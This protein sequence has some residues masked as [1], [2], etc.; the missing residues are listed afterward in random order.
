M[1]LPYKSM[2]LYA[3]KRLN[4]QI[5]DFYGRTSTLTFDVK[6]L[7]EGGKDMMYQSV[8]YYI[9]MCAQREMEDMTCRAVSTDLIEDY[10]WDKF[11]KEELNAAYWS[12]YDKSV[13]IK[14]KTYKIET[15]EEFE[16]EK[17]FIALIDRNKSIKDYLAKNPSPLT[18]KLLPDSDDLFEPEYLKSLG[19]TITKDDGQYGE[20]KSI[21]PNGKRIM[22][23]NRDN[24]KSGK[25][26][27]LG[28][29][30]DAG[31]RTVFGGTVET[32]EQLEL[33]LRL[34]K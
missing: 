23:W 3:I 24:M 16:L 25:V 4:I 11:T 20:A 18:P 22:N 13:T 9:G 14:N 6:Q 8:P 7:D 1:M 26:T 10:K 31:T 19:Y 2:S 29:K 27:W 5:M 15:K 33:L 21:N 34:A 30:E 28:I 12:S 32:R 17:E